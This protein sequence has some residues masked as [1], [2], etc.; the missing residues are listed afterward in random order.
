MLQIWSREVPNPGPNLTGSWGPHQPPTTNASDLHKE[1]QAFGNVRGSVKQEQRCQS[2][3]PNCGLAL[4]RSC[5]TGPPTD[6]DDDDDGSETLV[7]E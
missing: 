7:Q 1:N 6:D 2:H 4:T 3:G 5:G